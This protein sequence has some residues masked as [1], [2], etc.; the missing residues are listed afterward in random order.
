MDDAPSVGC[1]GTSTTGTAS[2]VT[3]QSDSGKADFSASDT[4]VD[5]RW[6][7]LTCEVR[8]SIK[9]HEVHLWSVS[10]HMTGSHIGG[11]KQ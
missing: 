11:L 9:A 8:F 6:V 7:C 4:G 5:G 10:T 1:R 2:T 3:R